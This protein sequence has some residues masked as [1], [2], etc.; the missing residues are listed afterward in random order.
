MSQSFACLPVQFVFSI[1]NREPWIREEWAQ[2]LYDYIGGI[3]QTEKSI[4]L[5]AGGVPNHVHL[6]VSLGREVSLAEMM[7]LVKT[8][9]SKWV[10]D[11]F[12]DHP[13]AWQAGYG[14]FGASYANLDPVRAYIARQKEHH[15]NLSF[16]DEYRGLL[17]AHGL[18]WDERYVWD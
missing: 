2:R 1:K 13:F 10:H 16:Q 7:R 3:V 15:A 6:L 14:A 8:N 4:L 18:E 12:P 17:R 11:T 9:S 5:A